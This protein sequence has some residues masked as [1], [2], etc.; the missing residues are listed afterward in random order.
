MTIKAKSLIAPTFFDLLKAVLKHS[1]REF[2]LLGGRGS[3]KSSFIS[4]AIIIL[5]IKWPLV[6]ALVVRKYSNT[7]RDSVY[8]QIQWAIDILGVNEL[9]KCTVSPL[10]IEYIPTGQQI[11]FRGVDKPV[12]LKSLKLARGYFGILWFE[13]STEFSP[14][15]VRSVKQT[16]MRGGEDFW[17]FDSFNPPVNRNNWKNKDALLD[18]PGR[19]V[20]RSDY[21]EVPVEWLSQAFIDEAEWLRDNNPRLYENEYLGVCTGSGLDVFENVHDITLT[22]EEIGAFDYYFHGIDWGYFPD[23]WR[24]VAMAYKPNTRELFIFDELSASKKGN[25]ETSDMLMRHFA[26][27]AWRWYNDV[28]PKSP[29]EVRVKLTPDSAEPKSISDYRSYGW[30]CHEPIKTGLRDYGFKW[31]QSLNA[32]YIDR[33][34]CPETWE[35][36]QNYSYEMNRD[37]VIENTYPEGQADHSL[38]CVRYAM[39]EVYRRRGL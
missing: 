36:F 10:K 30:N 16:V 7:L 32:I 34:R 18:K 9:F 22:D 2:C 4:I 38:A 20:H 13:E 8:E 39:E 3:T 1:Y 15:E 26:S 33:K 12:K 11:I 24:Y 5:I 6:N 19:I 29:R 21:R 25:A 23:P 14:E 31:L 28:E 27:G 35:E 17:I 37:G